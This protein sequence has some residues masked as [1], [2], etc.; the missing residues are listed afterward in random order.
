M[1]IARLGLKIKDM[2]RLSIGL[3]AIVTRSVWRF[4]SYN[5]C[6]SVVQI[7]TEVH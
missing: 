2:S 3:A 5:V 4:P 6:V 1:T 7:N